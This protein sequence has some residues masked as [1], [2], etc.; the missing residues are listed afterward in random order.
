MLIFFQI[1]IPLRADKIQLIAFFLQTKAR[2]PFA[3][4]LINNFNKA[5][6]GVKYGNRP[7]KQ[8]LY[9][10]GH[11]D[12]Y[13]LRWKAFKRPIRAKLHVVKPAADLFVVDYDCIV[14][15]VCLLMFCIISAGG[16]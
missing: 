8:R 9:R 10:I 15:Q 12:I 11:A 6:G 1:R 4:N 14:D 5:P 3:N 13:E 2:R 16:E 7:P